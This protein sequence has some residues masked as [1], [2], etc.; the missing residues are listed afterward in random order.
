M[1]QLTLDEAVDKVFEAMEYEKLVKTIALHDPTFHS[2]DVKSIIHIKRR[3]L[4]N[5]LSSF[6]LYEDEL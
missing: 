6:M 3:E 5:H 1:N 4:R 2:N